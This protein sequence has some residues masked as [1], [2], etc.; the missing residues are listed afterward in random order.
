E[1]FHYIKDLIYYEYLQST[2][3]QYPVLK[4]T[5]KAK[6]V[7]FKKEIVY[8]SS[9]VQTIIAKE[10]VIYQEHPYEKNLFENLKQL[11]NE[12]AHR[13]NVPAYVIFSDSTLI[14]L[15]TY[16]PLVHDDLAKISG[17]GAFKIEKYGPQFLQLIQEYCK[18]NSLESRIQLKQPKRERKQTVSSKTNNINATHKLSFAM[19][20]EGKTIS[21]IAEARNLSSQTIENHLSLYVASGELVIDEMVDKEKQKA[22]SKAVEE[23]GNKSLR[24]LKENLPLEISYADIRMVLASLKS[25]DDLL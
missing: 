8:L 10:P 13:E 11:R 6:D 22:I 5:Q 2:E 1:W 18:K 23:F 15:A 12:M 24:L 25:N 14:D 7:L 20:K 4:L 17:F 3:G 16:L 9:P 19:Y 21:E